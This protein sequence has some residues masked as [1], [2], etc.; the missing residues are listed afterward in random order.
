MRKSDAKGDSMNRNRGIDIII[1]VYNA[2]EDLKLCIESI[3]LHTDLVKNRV[4][5]IDD[6]S[7]DQNVY[8][9]MKS[10]EQ[11]GIVVLQN[12]QNQGFSGTINRGLQYSDRDVVLLNSDTI[13]TAGWLEKMIACAYSDRAI[14]TV[15]PFSN[16]ATLCSIPNFCEENEIPYGLSID[17][18]AQVIERCSMRSYPKITVA[19]GFCMLV[20]REVITAVGLF[21]QET[22]RKGYGEEND[23]CWRAEQM[24]YCHVLC[25]D[26]Y[27]YHRGTGSFVSEEKKALIA[28]HQAI[29]EKRYPKQEKQNAEYI[30]DNPHQYLR[31]NVDIYAKLKNGKKNILYVLHRD[32]R[33]DAKNNIGGTQFHVKDLVMHMRQENNVFVL[34]RDEEKLR[35]TVYLKQEQ[36][37]LSFHIG[38]E[39]E[40]QPFHS[41]EIEKALRQILVAFAID[42]VHVH[43]VQGLSFDLF[44]V[45]KELGI[46]LALTLHDFYYVCP[47]VLLLEKGNSYC[48]AQ[49]KDCAECLHVQ[50]GYAQQVAYLPVWRERCRQALAMCDVLF[51]PSAAVKE[52]YTSVYPEIAGRIR[53]IPH[54]MD[55]FETERPAFRSG[56]TPGFTFRVE[57]AF[58]QDYTISGWAYQEERDARNSEIFVCLEDR[59][60]NTAEYQMMLVSRLDVAQAKSN[61]NY[62]YSGFH[63]QVPDG[64]FASGDLKLQL[65][66]RNCGEEFHG[67]VV[68]VTG[69]VKREKNRKRIA[70]LGGLSEAKGSK[71]AYQLMN[72]SGNR[73]DWYIIGGIG[74][75]QLRALEKKNL[76]KTGWYKRE[77]ACSILRQNQI[78][79]VCILSICPETF[80]YTASE[81]ELAGIPI[82]A[83]DIGALGDRVRKD[84]T[85]WLIS[86]DTAVKDILE[87][88]DG[89]FA[90][91]DRF[92]QV[93]D[94]VKTFRHKSIR[95]MCEEYAELYK[96]LPVPEKRK[97]E[98][99]ARAIYNAYIL[100]QAEQS[101]DDGVTD[102]RLIR[103]VN[104][105]EAKLNAINRSLEYRLVK[106]F[107]REKIPFKNQIKAL[108]KFAY[109]VYKRFF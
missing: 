24:G 2:L 50:K 62:L 79:L 93:Q 48:C 94:H 86:P 38:K 52:I 108:I 106:F 13:V 75:Y 29:I 88:V 19:V 8:P 4:V 34:A 40:F 61:D 71:I 46:T 83:T 49:G 98:F 73:Y 47:T 59:E 107:N 55:A 87:T 85:G 14:G 10:I 1:P 53:V 99:D 31:N 42:I 37:A 26:T 96:I 51:A 35:L 101:G 81:A 21:D 100:C 54:G 44:D 76:F 27:I 92:A 68:T 39:P 74:D 43:H 6:R 67:D 95:E 78:D 22:F 102:V 23:F 82:L 91:E 36:F 41:K 32:F 84:Q 109:R 63:V 3:K 69:Y 57:H 105:L 60:G 33:A 5:L 80:C 28:E 7:P 103:R 12:E 20:K 90:D 66:I 45:T 70:F 104:E 89:I 56:I 16:N 72:L 77:N 9:Y 65:I 11:S 30:Q 17:E 18:Y 64:Y 25:D 97:A 58:E 15:T